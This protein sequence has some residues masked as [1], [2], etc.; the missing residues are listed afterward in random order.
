MGQM[1]AEPEKLKQVALSGAASAARFTGWSGWPLD[2]AI[3]SARRDAAIGKFNLKRHARADRRSTV[4][5]LAIG[6]AN[7]SKSARQY[8]TIGKCREEL[9][10][11][12][13]PRCAHRNAMPDRACGAFTESEYPFT[14]LADAR[15]MDGKIGGDA[16]AQS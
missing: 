6:I 11:A 14:L 2:W 8:A 7:Q 16:G 4:Q 1:I 9:T 12:F 10:A 13:G 15:A 3:F 5:R